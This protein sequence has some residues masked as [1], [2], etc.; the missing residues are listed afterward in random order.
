[1]APMLFGAHAA[2]DPF[3]GSGSETV[4]DALRFTTPSV[5]QVGEDLLLT[6]RLREW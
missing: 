2:R 1:M 6:S 3:E 4:A 5:Q